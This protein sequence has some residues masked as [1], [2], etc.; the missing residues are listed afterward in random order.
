[1]A[2]EASI[3]SALPRVATVEVAPDKAVSLDARGSI[4][5]VLTRDS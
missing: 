5:L 1:M 4:L 2:Q 3:L